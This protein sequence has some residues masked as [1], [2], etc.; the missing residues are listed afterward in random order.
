MH[1]RIVPAA[2]GT[3]KGLLVAIRNIF[4]YAQPMSQARAGSL[5]P[6]PGYFAAARSA[7]VRSAP[8]LS[9]STIRVVLVSGTSST[10]TTLPP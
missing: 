7:T 8:P 5:R 4:L 1:M 10:S 6:L 3:E 9:R 2:A